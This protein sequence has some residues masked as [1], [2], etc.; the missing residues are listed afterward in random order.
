MEN[1]ALA[2]QFDDKPP[3]CPKGH[4]FLKSG[5]VV[6]HGDKLR[7]G[8]KWETVSHISVGNVVSK[9]A[10]YARKDA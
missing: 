5:Q 6:Q 9:Y 2:K 1:P 8:G 4:H 10:Y 3:E 7:V